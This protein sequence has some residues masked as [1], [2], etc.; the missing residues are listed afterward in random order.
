M[1]TGCQNKYRRSAQDPKLTS[2]FPKLA[3]RMD[4][5]L[6]VF[7]YDA[8]SLDGGTSGCDSPLSNRHR[9]DGASCK[10]RGTVVYVAKSRTLQR[11]WVVNLT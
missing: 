11:I 1:P 6:L 9:T 4:D 2:D 10:A 7:I 5:W 3:I 8:S